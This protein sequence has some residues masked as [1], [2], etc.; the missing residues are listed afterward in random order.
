MLKARWRRAAEI[1]FALF[2]LAVAGAPHNH[3]NGLEDLLL[4]GPSDSGAVVITRGPI[5]MRIA[6]GLNPF[7]LV[8][9][10]PCLACFWSDRVS[11]PS[12][13]VA[14]TAG[15]ERLE[16]RIELPS[17]SRPAPLPQEAL[18]RAPPL[19]S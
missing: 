5:G 14:F 18:S 2:F 11:A 10:D 1:H 8:D 7:W 16:I 3:I 12:P 6:P 17:H 9:D 19:L 4:D 15:R 13:I